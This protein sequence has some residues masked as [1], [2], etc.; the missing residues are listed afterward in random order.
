MSERAG[1]KYM[2]EPGMVR[3]M[4]QANFVKETYQENDKYVG[5][6]HELVEAEPVEPE[7]SKYREYSQEHLQ[8]FEELRNEFSPIDVQPANVRLRFEEASTGLPTSGSW[9]NGA[10]V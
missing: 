9:R 5:V 7:P 1:A 2:P 6:W 3:P 8:Y 4:A 10:A